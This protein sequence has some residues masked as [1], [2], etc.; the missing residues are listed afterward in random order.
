[1]AIP[2]HDMI[3]RRIFT[4]HFVNARVELV[5]AAIGRIKARSRDISDSGVFVEVHPVP[6]LP[7][8]SHVKM[9][10]LDSAQPAIAFN[11]KVVRTTKHGVGLM[12]IDYELDGQ[13]F[14]IDTLRDLFKR[15]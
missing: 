14:S 9:H 11:M 3:E 1:M 7:N 8:G 12:F 2:Q 10:M 13:R 5:H 4:R 15:K 6:R